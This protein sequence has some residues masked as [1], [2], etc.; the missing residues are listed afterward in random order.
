MSKN[1]VF[2]EILINSLTDIHIF[3]I[4]DTFLY[5]PINLRIIFRI[6]SFIINYFINR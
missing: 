3:G 6:L 5:F 2:M 4:T 1:I